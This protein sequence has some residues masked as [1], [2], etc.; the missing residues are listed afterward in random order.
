MEG[1]ACSVESERGPPS[2]TTDQ[3]DTLGGGLVVVVVEEEAEVAWSPRS[4]MGVE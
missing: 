2:W 3:V 4:T 1:G